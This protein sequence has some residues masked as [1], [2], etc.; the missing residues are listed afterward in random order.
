[1]NL[2][3]LE[4]FTYVIYPVQKKT[5]TCQITMSTCQDNYVGLSDF[6]VDMS[7]QLCRLLMTG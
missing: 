1:M 5:A 6:Y 2:L 7:P 4:M 3:L